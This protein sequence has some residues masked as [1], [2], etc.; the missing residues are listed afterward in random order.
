M[1]NETEAVFW[2]WFPLIFAGFWIGIGFLLSWIGGWQALAGR[3]RATQSFTG[4]RFWMKSAAM[5]GVGY[6]NSVNL[7]ADSSGLY[8][9]VFPLFRAGHPPLFIPWSDISF[10]EERRWLLRGVRLQFREAPGVSLLIPT[11]LAKRIFANG[12]H[13]TGATLLDIEES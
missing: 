13:R 6:R 10:S 5:G 1:S 9:A 4:E 3:Y 2:P 11:N 8:L 12:P 7:G